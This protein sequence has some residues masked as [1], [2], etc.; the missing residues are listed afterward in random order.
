MAHDGLG[1]G[2]ENVGIGV[3]LNVSART[4]IGMKEQIEN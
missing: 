1:G 3:N 2:M 4:W